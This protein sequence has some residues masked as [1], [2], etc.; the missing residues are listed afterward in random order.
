MTGGSLIH[1][2]RD[3]I[4]CAHN[5]LAFIPHLVACLSTFSHHYTGSLSKPSVWDASVATT[6]SCVKTISADKGIK[7]VYRGWLAQRTQSH[8]TSVCFLGED[9]E[10]CCNLCQGEVKERS[11]SKADS[12]DC[13]IWEV[14]TGHMLASTQCFE[15]TAWRTL[16]SNK[17]TAYEK[18][19]ITPLWEAKSDG[20]LEN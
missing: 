17:H 8:I 5:K 3:H 12:G 14:E 9:T 15:A 10:R 1:Q 4:H 19:N 7:G 16:L 2:S 6:I 13:Y 11:Y 18:N 20:K